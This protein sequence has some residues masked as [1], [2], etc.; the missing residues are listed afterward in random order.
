MIEFLLTFKEGW[1]E[2][3]FINILSNYHYTNFLH[4]KQTEPGNRSDIT[5]QLLPTAFRKKHAQDSYRQAGA[6]SITWE[7][8]P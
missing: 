4:S 2:T 5:I 3:L 8:N 6:I 1:V 7:K